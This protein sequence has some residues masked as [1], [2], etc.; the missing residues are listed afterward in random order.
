MDQPYGIE[1]WDT[2]VKDTD[3]REWYARIYFTSNG[4]QFTT[5]HGYNAKYERDEAVAN[6]RDWLVELALSTRLEWPRY[7]IAIADAIITVRERE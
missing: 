6:Y 7:S 5:T 4:K 1:I 2:Q 3:D